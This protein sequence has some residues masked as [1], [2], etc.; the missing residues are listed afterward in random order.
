MKGWFIKK[1]KTFFLS[2]FNYR[3]K[4]FNHMTMNEALCVRL[5]DLVPPIIRKK[6]TKMRAE[7]N[8]SVR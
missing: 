1:E 4:M 5:L 8:P 2:Q 6:Y 3:T 7:I